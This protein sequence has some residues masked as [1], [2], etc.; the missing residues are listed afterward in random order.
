MEARISSVF[1]LLR[2]LLLEAPKRWHLVITTERAEVLQLA[3]YLG[4]VL[5]TSLI[6]PATTQ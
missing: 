2:F 6:I 5:H 3:F 1:D 4:C